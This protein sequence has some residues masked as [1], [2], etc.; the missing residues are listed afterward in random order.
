MPATDRFE[1]A[2]RPGSR[3]M[4]T[5]ALFWYAEEATPE[6]RPLVAAVMILDRLPDRERL[7]QLLARWIVR[8]PRL[9]QRVVEA[10]LHLGLPE[11]EDDPHFEL[12]YHARDVVL[13]EPGTEAQ[14][15]EFA[16]AVFATPL[17]HLRPLWEAYLIEGLQ[18]GRAACFFKVHHTVMDGVGSMAG[19]DSLT[20]N[21]RAE[22]VRVPQALPMH[23]ARPPAV[24][25]V[26][27]LRDLLRNSAE[28]MG[29][30]AGFWVHAALHPAEAGDDVLRAVRG[31][32]G[33]LRD[34]NAPA[35]HD[36]IADSTTG[37]G[38]RLDGMTLSLSRLRR[39]KDA[40]G[41]SLNDV[42]LTA[43]CGAV[44]R[45]HDHRGVHVD[46]LHCMVPINLRREH[47]RNA[48]GNRVG[49]C[50]I[51]LPVGETDPLMR[52]DIIRAQTN[53][54]KTDRRGAA[55]PLVMRALGFMPS[56]V[57][58]LLAQAVT[59]RINL[60][61]TNVPGPPAARYLAGAKIEAMYPFAPVAVGTPL[62]IALLSYG[63]VYGV[64]I[65]TD[66]A[67]IPDPERLHHY[68]AAEVDQLERRA[69]VQPPAAEKIRVPRAARKRPAARPQRAAS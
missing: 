37:I 27:L 41:V 62:S 15:F 20:Q 52:L 21:H 61:C 8:V 3:M 10:P 32:R 39:I 25:A 38:R 34:L 7:Q 42:V 26:R 43:V 6:L 63:D 5:D 68:L 44:G 9:R 64:G 57:F 69:R 65:D 51:A 45:Y 17:D 11:W 66:P 46:V 30:A 58:R 19:F 31:V 16:S 33:F 28:G 22:P 60:I 47:E 48:L 35:V 23:P 1:R 49:M 54:A 40:L 14:L 53:A 4:P 24:R 36:P 18:G 55:Y 67:A 13:P 59:G 29:A 50:N 12:A 56:V 2:A